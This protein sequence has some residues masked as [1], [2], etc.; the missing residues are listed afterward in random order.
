MHCPLVPHCESMTQVPHVPCTHAWPPSHWL[1][2]VQAAHAPLTQ[3]WPLGD[4]PNGKGN[5]GPEEE[6]FALQSPFVEHALQTPPR[7][8]CPLAQSDPDW[9]VPH[10]PLTHP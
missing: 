1:F 3:I 6:G 9:H 8:V 2:D 5:G 10:C 7:H 4:A